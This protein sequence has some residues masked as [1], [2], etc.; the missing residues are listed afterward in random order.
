[1]TQIEQIEIPQSKKKLLLWFFGGI[2]L[3]GCGVCTLGLVI[4]ELFQVEALQFG[5]FPTLLLSYMSIMSIV[6][7]LFFGFG[8]VVIYVKLFDKKPGLIINKQ[9]IID[10]VNAPDT[11]VLWS[12]IEKIEV[13]K[14]GGHW[15]QKF[16]MIII[17]NPQDYIDRATSPLAKKLTEMCI[18]KYGSPI[19][20][21]TGSLQIQFDDLWNLLNEKLNEYQSQKQ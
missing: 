16:L 13:S 10:N 14:I 18:K 3:T 21:S 19:G 8:T 7:V 9:G 15:G 2:F 12:D 1:M 17:K 11:V 6:G 4:A 5:L 20:I